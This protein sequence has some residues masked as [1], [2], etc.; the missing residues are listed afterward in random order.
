[1]V[2]RKRDSQEARKLAIQGIMERLDLAGFIPTKQTYNLLHRTFSIEDFENGGY[3][4]HEAGGRIVHLRRKGE[5][6]KTLEIKGLKR[7][8]R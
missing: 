2:L 1:M 6:F 3:L 7:Q 8:K 5:I 4:T